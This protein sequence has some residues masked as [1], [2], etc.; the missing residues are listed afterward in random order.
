MGRKLLLGTLALGA[1]LA[2]ALPAS[3]SARNRVEQPKYQVVAEHGSFEVRSYEPRLVAEVRVQAKTAELATNAGFRVLAS[4][5]F[6]NNE[7]RGEIAMTSPVGR[8]QSIDMT[9][10][11]GRKT[12]I[13][14]SWTI[15]FTM[16]SRWTLET[17]PKPKDPRVKI[18]QIPARR[19]AVRSFSGSPG[20]EKVDAR[21]TELR[22]WAREAGYRPTGEPA[23]YNRYD[24]PWVPAFARHNEI[25]LPLEGPEGDG[26]GSNS[27]S[28]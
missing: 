20:P 19:Y 10:P 25:W 2:V 16:P 9:A 14:G 6:G 1:A 18:R 26:A 28:G 15:S 12:D 13:D 23:A 3:A 27:T 11:V 24:P 8:S 17:L 7:A 4:F 5:I 22:D 21:E